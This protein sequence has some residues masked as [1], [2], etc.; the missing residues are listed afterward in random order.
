NTDNQYDIW[1]TNHSEKL[2]SPI[3]DYDFRF[4]NVI[5]ESVTLENFQNKIREFHSIVKYQQ[6]VNAIEMDSIYAHLSNSPNKCQ[7]LFI[8]V[9]LAY[10]IDIAQRKTKNLI[11]LSETFSSTDLLQTLYEI[12]SDDDLLPSEAKKLF[13]NTIS[14]LVRHNSSKHERQRFYNLLKTDVKPHINRIN[15][16]D[17]PLTYAII[18]ISFF[19]MESCD[20]IVK[21]IIGKENMDQ[22]I[23]EFLGEIIC[24]NLDSNNP[25]KLESYFESISEDLQVECASAFHKEFKKLMRYSGSTWNTIDSESMFKIFS[26][27]F[28]SESDIVEILNLLS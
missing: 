13:P 17:K 27:L 4:V 12:K 16:I 15:K 19:D 8:C 11:K 10:H 25:S 23:R 24:K 22:E 3:L 21:E 5:Y 26:Q 1:K 9:M 20:F 7:K 6:T 18:N 2:Y 28:T 14:A